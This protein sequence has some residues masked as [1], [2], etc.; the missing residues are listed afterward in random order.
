[1][2]N[3]ATDITAYPAATVAEAAVIESATNSGLTSYRIVDTADALAAGAPIALKE[4]SSVFAITPATVDEASAIQAARSTAPYNDTAYSIRDT[5]AAIAT[6]SPAVLNLAK[7]TGSL[8]GSFIAID[9]TDDQ[10]TLTGDQVT[11][12]IIAK[13]YLP[14]KL[15]L[16]APAAT[17]SALPSATLGD[18]NVVAINVSDSNE[19]TLT[20][21]QFAASRG[22]I[23]GT[24][25]I[26]ITS[27]PG[28]D[29]LDL[30]GAGGDPRK[31]IIFDSLADGVDI[32]FDYRQCRFHGDYGQPVLFEG[33]IQR[34]PRQ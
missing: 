1:M 26:R 4:A 18:P 34:L 2:L 5:G 11:P 20:A 21:A 24:D 28:T 7:D 13:F 19:I 6:A 32:I 14:E 8:A 30:N 15:T 16:S 10:V 27:D 17:L 9:A 31:A 29:T 12:E 23:D 22:L 3:G 25:P 33:G